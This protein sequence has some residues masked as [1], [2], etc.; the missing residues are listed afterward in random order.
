MCT[1]RN[2]FDVWFLIAS[3]SVTLAKVI[4]LSLSIHT[5]RLL[6]AIVAWRHQWTNWK[7]VGSVSR[8][9]R[10]EGRWE[11]EVTFYPLSH[12]LPSFPLLLSLSLHAP[13]TFLLPHSLFLFLRL[14]FNMIAMQRCVRLL[15][16]QILSRGWYGT[17]F[18]Q[19]WL[20]RLQSNGC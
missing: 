13:P 2:L 12:L 8:C 4:A 20:T 16:G 19:C 5:M 9:E 7:R 15:L 14:W 18:F 1:K 6:A 17:I 10:R 3:L 11:V